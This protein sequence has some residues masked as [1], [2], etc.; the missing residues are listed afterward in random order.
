MC[1]GPRGKP[2]VWYGFPKPALVLVNDVIFLAT[3]RLFK[4]SGNSETWSRSQLSP[5]QRLF[6]VYGLR[7]WELYTRLYQTLARRPGIAPL[8][9]TQCTL[10]L[11][12]ANCVWQRRAD[13]F[14]QPF[15]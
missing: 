13:A 6:C 7:L 12:R 4:D 1:R 10:S 14:P 15:S 9:Y 5:S 8:L 3:P 11:F 2:G